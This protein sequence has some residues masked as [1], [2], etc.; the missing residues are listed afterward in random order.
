MNPARWIS[1]LLARRHAAK[2]PVRLRIS[3]VT[4]QAELA[5]CIDV[6]DS[7]QK[8]RKGLLGRDKLSA[9]EGLWIVPCEAI[10]TFGMRFAI[11]LVYLD[12]DK[13]VKKVRHAVPP[14]RLSACF[15]AHSVL[16]LASGSVHRTGTKP[17]DRL[18]FCSEPISESH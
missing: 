6:A 17:G 13:K 10:H 12:R 15:S 18:E 1:G 2:P 9:G 14:G 11:D 7:V 4:R 3:N 8:R 5:D 16:E